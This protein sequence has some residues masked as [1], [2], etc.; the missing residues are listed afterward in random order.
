M[1]HFRPTTHMISKG[2][3]VGASLLAVL[4]PCSGGATVLITISNTTPGSFIIPIGPTGTPP[5]TFQIGFAGSFEEIL[6]EGFWRS[7]ALEPGQWLLG[8]PPFS[9][10]GGTSSF[11]F[12][13]AVSLSGVEGTVDWTAVSAS[14]TPQLSGTLTITEVVASGP[15]AAQFAA[16]FPIGSVDFINVSLIHDAQTQCPSNAP[17]CLI[18]GGAPS[19]RRSPRRCPFSVRRSAFISW[20]ARRSAALR[21]QLAKQFK[22][23]GG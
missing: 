16:D 22:P 8:G 20:S 12:G 1:F 18:V 3:A 19:P 21:N 6:G 14:F 17:N 9:V 11:H 4:A 23:L 13:S 5:T 15:N 2:F 10:P 7:S